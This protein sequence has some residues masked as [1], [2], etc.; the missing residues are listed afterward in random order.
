MRNPLFFGK[1][2]LL[3]VIVSSCV[4]F[5]L[6]QNRIDTHGSLDDIVF[7]A[8]PDYPDESTIGFDDDPVGK[9]RKRYGRSLLLIGLN[10]SVRT[11]NIVPNSEPKMKFSPDGQQIIITSFDT[12]YIITSA[13]DHVVKLQDPTPIF[14]YVGV[15]D[16]GEIVAFGHL[17]SDGSGKGFEMSLISGH[18]DNVLQNKQLIDGAIIGCEDT[19][20]LFGLDPNRNDPG[21]FRQHEFIYNRVTNKFEQI[22]RE[23]YSIFHAIDSYECKFD[24]LGSFEFISNTDLVYRTGEYDASKGF[25]F[26]DREYDLVSYD[27]DY[28]PE[29]TIFNGGCVYSLSGYGEM[30][31]ID[32]NTGEY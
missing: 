28:N 25:R 8:Y 20:R 21:D 9:D 3:A 26:N 30:Y 6:E 10:D 4:L 29:N 15:N 13:V 5:P 32:Q 11:I 2:L 14:R 17:G 19:Y 12:L 7:V 18:V 1:L 27:I 24:G 23:G 31:K 22:N 16:S